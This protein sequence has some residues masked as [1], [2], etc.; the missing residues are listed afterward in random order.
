MPDDIKPPLPGWE[1][2]TPAAAE[3][4]VHVR[5]LVRNLEEMG[6]EFM[7]WGGMRFNKAADRER[8]LRARIQR[9]NQPR[10]ARR[11]QDQHAI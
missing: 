3:H 10:R 11:A 2:T 9:R 1:A 8:M 5:T 6:A 4:G 7:Y